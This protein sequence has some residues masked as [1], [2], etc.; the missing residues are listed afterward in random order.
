LYI[1]F[2]YDINKYWSKTNEFII[3]IVCAHGFIG[4]NKL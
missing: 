4:I 1:F 3:K 2:Y